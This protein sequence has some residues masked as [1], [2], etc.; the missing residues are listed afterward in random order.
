MMSSHHAIVEFVLVNSAETE[1]D[2]KIEPKDAMQFSRLAA[3]SF[4]G[5]KEKEKKNVEYCKKTLIVLQDKEECREIKEADDVLIVEGKN[6]T[7][8][9]HVTLSPD[10]HQSVNH[11]GRHVTKIELELKEA[12]DDDDAILIE[13]MP[14]ELNTADE[15]NT[16][17][18][19]GIPGPTAVIVRAEE[20][21][22][23]ILVLLLWAAAIALFF[24]RWGKIRMLEPYQPKFQQQ[25]RQSCTT[26]EQNQLEVTQIT[27]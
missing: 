18:T 26:I 13:S 25:H 17:C 14:S 15:I 23:V 2:A 11:S 8:E 4:V 19:N 20:V 22:I 5:R 7:E 27:A 12:P 1:Y 9:Y 21:L 6:P 3:L 16:T 10:K 24:N